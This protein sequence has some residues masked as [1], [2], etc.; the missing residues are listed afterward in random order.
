MAE[1]MLI[2]HGYSDSSMSFKSLRDFF[3]EHLKID[4]KDVFHTDYAS[5]DDQATFRDFA[6]KLDTD[7]SKHFDKGE[8][9]NVACHSTGALVVRSWLALRRQRQI[10]LG[11]KIDCPV[12]RILFF[13]PANFGSDLASMGQSVLGRLRSTFF[14][15]FSY[16]VE[17]FFESGKIV[18][19]ALE[20]ASPFQWELSEMDLHGFDYF[21]NN[22]DENL[23]CYPFVFA[24]GFDYADKAESFVVKAR[25]KPG[26]DGTVRICG[27]NLNTRKCTIDFL[28]PG[29][30]AKV[31][32][33]KENKFNHIPFAVFHEMNHGSLIEANKAPFKR[34][35]GPKSLVKKAMSVNSSHEYSEVAE[36]FREINE[37]NYL[38]AEGRYKDKYQQFFFSARDDVDRSV[39]DYYIH[40]YVDN[41]LTGDKK[42]ELSKLSHEIDDQLNK[43]YYKHSADPSCRVLMLKLNSLSEMQATLNQSKARLI[44][45]VS[46]A[47]PLPNIS[48][49]T[50]TF[51]VYDGTKKDG[52][53]TSFLYPNTTTLVDLIL[54]RQ[55]TDKLI[56]LK[57]H[58]LKPL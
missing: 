29:Q 39:E 35:I 54:N 57:D 1:K 43:K 36:K 8:R 12:K 6:D 31:K 56:N 46:A 18:L 28:S 51:V 16:K 24:A 10:E 14:N 27:T 19:Q 3:V 9:I 58:N 45:E 48:Y 38:K 41:G 50:G 32:W 44:M 40:F 30:P 33:H 47:S 21:L 20:P 11:L 13:A 15:P 53:G 37:K 17:D 4:K 52:E 42:N 5:M 22:E 26:T 2:I 34:R 49:K 7:Y 55:Q 23:T 25:K